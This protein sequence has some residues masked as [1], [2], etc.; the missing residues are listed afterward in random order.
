MPLAKLHHPR[1]IY[2]L[3][4]CEA[5]DVSGDLTSMFRGAIFNFWKFGGMY[6]PCAK[7]VGLQR[8]EGLRKHLLTYTSDAARQLTDAVGLLQQDNQNQRAPSRGDVV[9]NAA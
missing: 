3:P 1:D 2:L 8:L 6:G 4:I 5:S 7:S 9:E